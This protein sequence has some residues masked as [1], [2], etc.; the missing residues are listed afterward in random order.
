VAYWAGEYGL[1][2]ETLAAVRGVGGFRTEAS[3]ALYRGYVD[4]VRAA[5]GDAARPT[6]AAQP[7]DDAL[8]RA[9]STLGVSAG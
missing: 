8:D 1:A 3:F 2:S 6:Q 5:F 4:R 9:L 7:I